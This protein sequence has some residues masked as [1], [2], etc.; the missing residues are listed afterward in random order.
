MLLYV[1]LNALTL[2]EHEAVKFFRQIAA[3]VAYC[4][5]KGFIHRDLKPV[6]FGKITQLPVG[7]SH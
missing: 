4:H 5:S 7:V 2:Q 1:F 6:S 3:A